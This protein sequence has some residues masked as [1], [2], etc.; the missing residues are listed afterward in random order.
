[1]KREEMMT[2][3]GW[4]REL[5]ASL[6]L[7]H[8]GPDP[9]PRSAQLRASQGRLRLVRLSLQN[10]LFHPTS[11]NRLAQAQPTPRL[12]HTDWLTPVAGKEAP[13]SAPRRNPILNYGY[14]PVLTFRPDESPIM[15]HSQSNS[16][17]TVAMELNKALRERWPK[18][19][20]VDDVVQ[21]HSHMRWRVSQPE[22]GRGALQ[23]PHTPTLLP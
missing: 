18:S 14:S 15:I 16:Q 1:M 20:H 8:T 2:I 11:P 17:G 23:H 4:K 6:N 3:V 22:G 9:E 12:G 19:T 5:T 10:S 13:P 7:V 21:T